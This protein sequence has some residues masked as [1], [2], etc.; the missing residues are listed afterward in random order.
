[1]RMPR[2]ISLLFVLFIIGGL[3]IPSKGENIIIGTWKNSGASKRNALTFTFNKDGSY[4]F[5]Y[6]V[7]LVVG[8]LASASETTEVGRYHVQGV[9]LVLTP[10]RH[11]GWIYNMSPK[12][13]VMLKKENRP[14]R[15]Y[16]IRWEE[17]FLILRGNCAEFQVNTYCNDRKGI[18]MQHDF[19]L[20]PLRASP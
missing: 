1:M 9:N 10:K 20:K 19:I 2:A 17:E 18:P 6:R 13:K 12:N 11:E 16:T 8:A 15:R 7:R 14:A 4:R 3:A 5:D